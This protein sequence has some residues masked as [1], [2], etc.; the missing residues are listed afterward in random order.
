MQE[1][2]RKKLP[3]VR[4][5]AGDPSWQSLHLSA[6]FAKRRGRGRVGRNCLCDQGHQG[7]NTEVQ[8]DPPHAAVGESFEIDFLRIPL[9]KAPHA[10]VP[11]NCWRVSA[12][13]SCKW[14]QSSFLRILGDSPAAARMH[15][16]LCKCFFA[17]KSPRRSHQK[18]M[19]TS[20]AFCH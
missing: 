4:N 6:F 3:T 12:L 16:S 13:C 5:G 8:R 19:I 20:C 1:G 17:T 11:W 15:V 18:V 10:P 9:S 7:L 2:R 14:H